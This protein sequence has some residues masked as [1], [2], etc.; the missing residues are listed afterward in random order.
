M[1]HRWS[2]TLGIVLIA[3]MLAGCNSGST[4][5]NTTDADTTESTAS[6]DSSQSS[7]A[8][9][10][11]PQMQM[12]S[13]GKI[14]SIDG[15]TITIYTSSQTGMGGGPQ[16]GQGNGQPP[17]PPEGDN[18]G[19]TGGG[20][21]PQ[22]GTAPSGDLPSSNGDAQ[23]GD[24][25]AQLGQ[26]PP[27]G[28]ASSDGQQPPQGGMSIDDMFTDET[29]TLQL[30]DTTKILKRSFENNKMTE[31]ELTVQDLQVDDIINYM[32]VDGTEDQLASITIGM[33]GFG[34]GG[35]QRS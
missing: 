7:E 17:Q 12:G 1:N 3:A 14:Q 25:S 22:G 21:P 19:N 34:G 16:D 20:Q 33:G 15:H 9:T 6:S 11:Q 30:T 8:K 31:T 23:A 32:L 28:Q 35:G 5:A 26:V 27:D 18:Q 29:L 24:S 10:E 4:S 2:I 13:M